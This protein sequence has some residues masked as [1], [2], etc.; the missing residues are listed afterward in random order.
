MVGPSGVGKDTLLDGAKSR[1]V[2]DTRFVFAQRDITRPVEPMGEQ[3]L[4]VTQEQFADMEAAGDYSLHW[5]AHGNAYGIRRS[6]TSKLE[7]GQTVIVSGSRAILDQVRRQFA[8]AQ[9]I[10]ITAGSHALRQRLEARQRE[11]SSDIE[12]RI[13]R[14]A[15]FS[16]RGADV[17]TIVNDQDIETGINALTRLLISIAQNESNGA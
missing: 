3:H 6:I 17:H 14:A 10:H 15:A 7:N 13:E 1:L 9:I 12:R 8:G 16:I 11:S 4:E 2:G 5:R